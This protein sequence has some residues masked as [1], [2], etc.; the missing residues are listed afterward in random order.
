MSYKT[1][2]CKK[3]DFIGVV[4]I[5]CPPANA[6]TRELIEDL[7]SVF[8]YLSSDDSIRSVLITS[9][10]KKIFLS[11]GDI[12]SSADKIMKGDSNA[13]IDYVRN[14]QKVVDKV[15]RMPKPTIAS[16]NGH[17][18]G[19]GFEFVVACDFRTMSNNN[20][21]Q[22]GMPEIDIGFIPGLG[23]AYRVSRK[24][25]QH[26]ALKMGLGHRLTAQEAFNMGLVDQLY[27]PEELF[28]QSIKFAKKLGELPTKAVALIKKIVIEGYDKKIDD[29]YR[30][31][32]SC[33]KKVLATEDAIEGINAFLEK[34]M[35]KFKGN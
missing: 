16:I 12:S 14:I 33:L 29:V 9:L 23:G 20:R 35:P 26:L 24:F 11:G 15:E 5:N 10:N 32:L 19:G 28:S 8:D 22:L 3:E 4:S 7:H 27:P 25:G 30:L 6:F 2:E 31:E 21:I 18:L 34:R 13:Q 17:A 1:I